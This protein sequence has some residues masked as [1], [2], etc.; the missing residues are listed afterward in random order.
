MMLILFLF[1][2]MQGFANI[3]RISDQV[4]RVSTHGKPGFHSNRSSIKSNQISEAS[5]S[6]SDSPSHVESSTAHGS[7]KAIEDIKTNINSKQDVQ[8]S[9]VLIDDNNG[10]EV[11]IA[12]DNASDVVT[13]TDSL[14]DVVT[15]ND[16]L[17]NVVS[18]S[19]GVANIAFE[20]AN[21]DLVSEESN[22]PKNDNVDAIPHHM[23]SS[24][25]NFDEENNQS[26]EQ[27][28]NNALD[29]SNQDEHEG[30][31]NEAEHVNSVFEDD[32]Y[33]NKS[34]TCI[35]DPSLRQGNCSSQN[36]TDIY[37]KS[38]TINQHFLTSD[39]KSD[40]ENTAGFPER[41]MSLEDG[42]SP[43][44]TA[45]SIHDE[46]SVDSSLSFSLENIECTM[47]EDENKNSMDGEMRV[48]QKSKNSQE[49]LLYNSSIKHSN[50]GTVHKDSVGVV[51]YENEEDKNQKT[52]NS[53]PGEIDDDAKLYDLGSQN[54]QSPRSVRAQRHKGPFQIHN[55]S[56]H[57]SPI[58]E[59]SEINQVKAAGYLNRMILTDKITNPIKYT[60]RT[61]VALEEKRTHSFY[62]N[63]RRATTTSERSIK[64]FSTQ[65]RSSTTSLAME[66]QY[67]QERTTFTQLCFVNISFIFGYIPITVYLLWTS[68]VNFGSRDRVIDY[69]FGVIA[70][71]CL[72]ISECMNPI[73]Y[74]LASSNIGDATRKLLRNIF[75]PSNAT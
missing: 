62:K 18:I 32:A 31:H 49:I 36:T 39:K 24:T 13:K 6:S 74:N 7:L 66:R 30:L 57:N 48:R 67:Q 15:N 63:Q 21:E 61:S 17:R 14:S 25:M 41:K 52:L 29:S 60:R 54:F 11:V 59:E 4:Q 8:F 53:A 65:R 3:Y 38:E 64:S 56:F 70:Y 68:N 19:E 47:S 45:F 22:Y 5:F 23:L 16:N 1:R 27:D 40:V 9:D 73:I 33:T 26:N 50:Y 2:W 34:P 72:R 51:N 75:K 58:P 20:I 44:I 10:S 35:A 69:W 42:R 55:S 43:K 46:S 37:Q 12:D 71:I 28:V